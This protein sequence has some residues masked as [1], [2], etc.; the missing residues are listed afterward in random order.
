M[1][2]L[3]VNPFEEEKPKI[4]HLEKSD[5]HYEYCRMQMHD[6]D[7]V[8]RRTF[9]C[10][11]VLCIIVCFFSIFKKYI[12]MFDLLSRPYLTLD[13]PEAILT[14]GIFQ[15]LFGMAIIVLGYLAWANYRTLNI[16]LGAWYAM[17]TLIGVF[18][19][20]YL[21]ALIGV[22]GVVFYYFSIRELRR[23]Q[24]LA[25]MEGY[26]E[27][28]EKFDISKSDIVIQTLLAHQGERRTK[29]TLFTTDYSL[30]RKKKKK[31]EFGYTEPEEKDKAEEAGNALVESLQKHLNEARS[32]EKPAAET[33]P[34]TVSAEP[35]QAAAEALSEA[36]ESAVRDVKDQ[37]EATDNA[38]VESLQK[39]LVESLQKHLNEVRSTEQHD[40]EAV[41]AE[42]VSEAVEAA[43]TDVKDQV[44]VTDNAL[45]ESLQKQLVK[46]LQ[47]HLN[48]VRST[49]KPAAKPK[50]PAPTESR[51]ETVAPERADAEAAAAAILAEAEARTQRI[52]AEAEAK[53]KALTEGQPA[54]K[55]PQKQGGQNPNPNGRKKKRR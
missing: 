45:V 13:K 16:I 40:A 54:K 23:E 55:E 15:I 14:G 10:N 4:V 12:A 44:E 39:Q 30:R 21:S 34:E 22:V 46:L 35:E 29:S 7:K 32:T 28:H 11:L 38:L 5:S 47:K 19:L 18:R 33:E 48:E 24:A 1:S 27:F 31:T 49:E 25:Q 37:V 2:E 20:D 26:P 8:H 42:A 3:N 50:K 9:F 17:V 6:I 51:H 52:L 41:S 53:I 36:A 43:M